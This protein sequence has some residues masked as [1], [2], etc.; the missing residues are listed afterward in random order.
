MKKFTLS[1]FVFSIFHLTSYMCHAVNWLVGPAKTYTMPS[2]V[3]TLV[4]SGDTVSIDAATYTGDVCKW[5]ANNLLIRGVN[6]MATLDANNTSYGQKGIFVIDGNNCTVEY[7]EFLHCHDVVGNSKNWAGIRFEASGITIRNCYFH[8][9]DDGI[10]DNGVSTSPI[11][12]EFTEF[13]HNGYGDGYSHNLYINHSDTLI[14]RYNYSHLASIGHELKSRASVNYILYNR[15]S[16]EATGDASRE[17]DLP[18]GGMAIVMGNI[19]EQGPNSTNSGIIEYGLEGLTNPAPNNFYFINNTVVNDKSNGTFITLQTGMDLYKA[20]NNIFAGP[21]TLLSGSATTIDTMKNWVVTTI[22]NCGFVNASNYDYH[23]TAGSG[24][25]NAGA[26]AGTASNG[27]NLTPALEYSHPANNIPRNISGVIDVGAHEYVSANGILENT[28]DF[29][30]SFFISNKTLNL[31]YDSEKNASAKIID[32]N[33]RNLKE[34]KISRGKSEIDISKFESGIYILEII[35][36]E[37]RKTGIFF[38]Q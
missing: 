21:G 6:G 3:S 8:D 9:N 16:N 22:A 10:L 7:I 17:M 2:Q 29:N 34:E 1:L 36:G 35:S 38:L 28:S 13:A 33:G 32:L 18:N 26:N 25:I 4:A 15:F 11:L 24:A 30:F 37:Q 23:L 20:Y 31:F 12:I 5:T 19:I 27:Y 14:F